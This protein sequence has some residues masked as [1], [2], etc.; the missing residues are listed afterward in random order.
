MPATPEDRTTI[1][2]CAALLEQGRTLHTLSRLLTLFA[3]ALLFAGALELIAKAPSIIIAL[4][5]I[6]LGVAEAWFAL[7]VGFD[8]ALLRDVANRTQFAAL[9][10]AMIRLDLIAPEKAG[11]PLDERLQG[12]MRLMRMQGLCLGGQI[13]VLIVGALVV[14]ILQGRA[15]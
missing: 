15:A 12:A 14:A 9:D 3:V 11:R 4:V 8:A 7:R 6:G 10:T 5:V 2:A 13:L 1:D